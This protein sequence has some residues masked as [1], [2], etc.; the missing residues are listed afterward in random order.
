LIDEAKERPDIKQS[1]VEDIDE[2]PSATGSVQCNLVKRTGRYPC[3]CSDD[4]CPVRVYIFGGISR[5]CNHRRN[6]T[7][8]GDH[9]DPDFR[10]AYKKKYAE[11]REH[12]KP[13]PALCSG[14][15][16]Q[17][18]PCQKFGIYGDYHIFYSFHK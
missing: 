17:G 11:G 16:D 5:S 10:R 2:E 15:D 8:P 1:G 13:V 6:G 14:F 18:M 4:E 7:K 3:A 9:K 12:V